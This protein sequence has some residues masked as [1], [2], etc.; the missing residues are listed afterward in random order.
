MSQSVHLIDTESDTPRAGF[1]LL[2]AVEFRDVVNSLKQSGDLPSPASSRHPSR[3]STPLR[4]PM[5]DSADS[6]YFHSHRTKHHRHSS[7]QG[8]AAVERRVSMTRS[9]SASLHPAWSGRPSRQSTVEE[10]DLSP[11]SSSPPQPSSDP[12]VE[13]IPLAASPRN[14]HQLT[15]DIPPQEVTTIVASSSPP[16]TAATATTRGT[17]HAGGAV[18]PVSSVPQIALQNEDGED[19]APIMPLSRSQTVELVARRSLNTVRLVFHTLFPSLQGFR[20]KSIVGMVLAVLSVPAIFILTLTLP[21]I[22]DGRSDEGGVVLPGGEDEPL[23]DAT[24]DNE[25][26]RVSN[27]ISG[28]LHH[29][30]HSGYPHRP[31]SEDGDS[32]DSC[33]SCSDDDDCMV[34]NPVLTAAQCIVGPVV[35]GY[36]VFRELSMLSDE[37]TRRGRDVPPLGVIGGRVGW[38]PRGRRRPQVRNGRLVAAVASYPLLLRV[39]LQYGVDWGHCRRG[40]GNPLDVRR[41]LRTQRR[42]HRSDK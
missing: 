35:C 36:L 42:N 24:R 39:H 14:K 13:H 20:H 32:E 16:T 41:D 11:V 15:L 6:D 21:V 19:E 34:F 5:H 10:P 3:P 28:E 12:D 40:C 22:D 7:V 29:L 26:H 30:V 27:E 25:E 37:L 4:S 8:L 31:R 1:S 33:S 38:R 17:A 18:T 2:G 9:R 23:A